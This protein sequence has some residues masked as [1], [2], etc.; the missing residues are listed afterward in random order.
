MADYG[1]APRTTP[2]KA[3]S[4]DDYTVSEIRRA[5]ATG[6]YDIRG[7]GAK[8]RVPCFDDLVFLGASMSR[9]PLEGYREACGTD[10]ILGDRF[11]SK[12]LHL[13]RLLQLQDI[14]TATFC[15]TLTQTVD[16]LLFD[17]PIEEVI[18]H[19]QLTPFVVLFAFI[20]ALMLR[21]RLNHRHLWGII[22]Y[23]GSYT[24]ISLI[25][26]SSR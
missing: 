8:R 9:Y 13:K 23:A 12:P 2:R 15:Y 6:I 5:A 24:A 1:N 20:A 21:P 3:A 22:K 11:A 7:G 10:V 14:A 16:W 4:F 25:G 19:L 17:T 26:C 18:Y